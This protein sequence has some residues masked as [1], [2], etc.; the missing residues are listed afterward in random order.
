MVDRYEPHESV[1]RFSDKL[2]TSNRANS[3][4]HSQICQLKRQ[5]YYNVDRK[6][7]LVVIRSKN[8]LHKSRS[9]GWL[10][11]PEKIRE[12]MLLTMHLLESV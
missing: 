2:S 8:K 4:G 6:G 3:S 9:T 10:S 5:R 1:R 12:I 11:V 7:L